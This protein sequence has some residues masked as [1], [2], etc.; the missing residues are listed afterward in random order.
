MGIDV[1]KGFDLLIRRVRVLTLGNVHKWVAPPC[2]VVDLLMLRNRVFGL[3]I[4]Q[5]WKCC[6]ASVSFADDQ[7]SLIHL[8]KRSNVSSAVMKGLRFPDSQE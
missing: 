2:Y 4:V 3:R 6:P 8:A 5:K 1:L 7:E